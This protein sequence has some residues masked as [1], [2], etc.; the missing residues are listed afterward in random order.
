M[1]PTGRNPKSTALWLTF[2]T[3]NATYSDRTPHTRA[4]RRPESSTNTARGRPWTNKDGPRRTSSGSSAVITFSFF[5]AFFTTGCR[6]F[7]RRRLRPFGEDAQNFAPSGHWTTTSPQAGNPP[8]GMQYTARPQRTKGKAGQHPAL[9]PPVVTT[10]ETR[11]PDGAGSNPAGGTT[12]ASGHLTSLSYPAHVLPS[13]GRGH[14]P[15][16]QLAEWLI[17]NQQ[18]VGSSPTWS[19]MGSLIHSPG[20]PPF[21]AG[22]G[23]KRSRQH[24]GSRETPKA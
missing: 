19:S 20:Y 4:E 11:A 21:I 8:T 10:E 14:A 13:V 15:V 18:V 16:A 5:C 17:C 9:M 22:S 3:A 2:A 1:A 6:I 23:A 12:R 24:A 7:P